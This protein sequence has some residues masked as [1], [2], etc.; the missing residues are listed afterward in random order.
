[1]DLRWILESIIVATLGT[2]SE[3]GVVV[4]E[5]KVTASCDRQNWLQEADL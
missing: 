5:Q 1:M 3:E 4:T 2:E